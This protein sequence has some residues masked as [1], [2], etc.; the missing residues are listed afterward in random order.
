MN[1][2]RGRDVTASELLRC[3]IFGRADSDH[4][5]IDNGHAIRHE[6]HID[7]LR[8][9]QINNHRLSGLAKKD[10][11]RLQVAMDHPLGV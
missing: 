10:I 7:G 11:R 9:S 5:A 1:I 6:R 3:G 2:C 4:L 8:Q